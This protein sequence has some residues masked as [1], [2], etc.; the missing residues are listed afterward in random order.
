MKMSE[1]NAYNGKFAF[2]FMRALAKVIDQPDGYVELFKKGVCVGCI[3][4]VTN[5]YTTRKDILSDYRWE[6]YP[7]GYNC[8][9][10]MWLGD[11]CIYFDEFNEYWI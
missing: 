6:S 9:C 8:E 4:P 10:Y 1:D 3:K 2:A 5:D 11:V 7:E